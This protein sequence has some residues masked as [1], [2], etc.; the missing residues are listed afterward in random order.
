LLETN[1][2]ELHSIYTK[3]YPDQ[4]SGV[5]SKLQERDLRAHRDKVTRAAT[6]L[7][8]PANEAYTR[9]LVQYLAPVAAKLKH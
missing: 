4:G 7:C 2:R 3:G 5:V 6:A 9:G 8:A 1:T